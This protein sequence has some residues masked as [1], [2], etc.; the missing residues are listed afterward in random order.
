MFLALGFVKENGFHPCYKCQF[1]PSKF[2][3][4]KHQFIPL[5]SNNEIDLSLVHKP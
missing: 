4:K 5:V 1:N 2:H 3:N